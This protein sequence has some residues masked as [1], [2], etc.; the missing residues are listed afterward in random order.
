MDMQISMY[1]YIQ[2]GL[3]E[4]AL[5]QTTSPNAEDYTVPGPPPVSNRI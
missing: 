3:Y 5:K 1:I 2:E 4:G